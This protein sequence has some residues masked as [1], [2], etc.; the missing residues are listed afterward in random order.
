MQSKIGSKFGSK[1]ASDQSLPCSYASC[2]PQRASKGSRY[3]QS[4]HSNKSKQHIDSSAHPVCNTNLGPAVVNSSAM[5]APMLASV[6]MHIR[7]IAFW[8]EPCA[9][10]RHAFA[11]ATLTSSGFFIFGGCRHV[12]GQRPVALGDLWYYSIGENAWSQLAPT[13]TQ[14]E[15]ILGPLAPI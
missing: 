10:R 3:A 15:P 2:P 11:A 1:G 9:G 12:K 8:G 13:W 5:C 6:H 14:L 7:M 4:S